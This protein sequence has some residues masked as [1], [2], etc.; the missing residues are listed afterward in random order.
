MKTIY[1]DN[2]AT[3]KT[4]LSVLRA[5]ET[6]YREY[7]APV[8]RG[9]YAAS[10]R[11]SKEYEAAR[12]A[13]AEFI[14]AEPR[15]IVFTRGATDALNQLAVMLTRDLGPGDE[16]VL[17][18]M[19][20]HSNLLPWQEAARRSGLTLKFIPITVAG[21]LD[22]DAADRLI[23]EK[24]KI[25]AFTH[26]S[27]AIGTR[28]P[29]AELARRA[30]ARGAIVVVDGAQSVPHEPVDV[31]A[32]GADFLVFSGHKMC[33]PTG[34][35]VLYGKYELL[36]ALAP[37]IVGGGIVKSVT[38]ESADYMDAPWRFE[39]GTPPVAEAIG[40][41]AAVAYLKKIGLEKINAR[42]V[43]L[44]RYTVPLLKKINGITVYGMP[45]TGI[46][47]FTLKGTHPHDLADILDRDGIAVRSGHHCAMPLMTRLGVPGTVR[48]SFY[49]YNTRR[50]AD[51]LVR[52][53][54]NAA[55]ILL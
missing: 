38:L 19:E 41:G 45:E 40:L 53:V 3:S 8:H 12:A 48:A 26:V 42:E 31:R 50:D 37:A 52:G 23:T 32:L 29:V 33:G 15:E 30:H 47:S 55:R 9:A 10:I 43:A 54:E 6:Y 2:A 7:R 11:A 1:L 36:R 21:A 25:L 13:V 16:I 4:P 49:F 17:T 20:H 28:N 14:G 24:T 18:E 39:A 22:L 27:N 44:T 34:V 46:I 35:G 5:M 51:A